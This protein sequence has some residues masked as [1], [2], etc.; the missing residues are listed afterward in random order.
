MTVGI[1]SSGIILS[2]S[3]HHKQ[4]VITVKLTQILTVPV[5]VKPQYILV[6]PYL[7]ATQR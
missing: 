5:K 7:T 6:K 4:K 3:V 1:W 2:V